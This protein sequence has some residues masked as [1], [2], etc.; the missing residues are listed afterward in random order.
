MYMLCKCKRVSECVLRVRVCVCV[1]EK[2][3]PER[4]REKVGMER[5]DSFSQFNW[6]YKKQKVVEHR[7]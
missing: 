2:I 1:S 4:K 3:E 6:L 7:S 5:Q